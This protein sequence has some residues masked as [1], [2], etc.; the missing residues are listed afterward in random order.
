MSYKQQCKAEGAILPRIKIV[1]AVL[2]GMSQKEVA[3]H[4]RCSKN[5]VGSLMRAYGTLSAEQQ[6]A[7]SGDQSL[8]AADLSHF[9]ALACRSRA[10]R[11]N[12]RSLAPD[13]AQVILDVHAGMTMGPQR[14]RTHLSRQGAC[15]KT[16]TLAKIKG[17]YKRHGLVAKKVRTANKQRRSL[18]DYA[19]LA[20]FER[21]HMDTKHILDVHALPKDI[22]EKFRDTP[23]LPIYQWTIQDAKTRMRF[24]AYSHELSSFFGQRFLLFALEWLRAH[25]V[26]IRINVLFDGGSEFCSASA[27]KLAHWQ[28]FFEP[29]GVTVSQTNGDKTRQNLIERS[30]RSDDEEFYCPRGIHIATKTDFLLEAQ[31]WNIYWNCDRAHSG[32]GMDDMTPSEKLS[33]L[34]YAN[35]DAI[36]RFPT[37]ILE[38]IHRELL[39]MPSFMAAQPVRS[40]NVLTY[41]PRLQK[42][43]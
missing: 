40:Q 5:T 28:T 6:Q 3:A 11:G 13:E 35:V 36:G 27:R 9:T 10:P 19:R 16:Y 42:T 29:Y 39:S 14:M 21:L 43:P 15:M 1:R 33:R 8:A 41:Y 32:I 2:S 24:L 38:D 30:H 12:K 20:A 26:F 25:G 18:Y 34:G 4:W 22:Y 31:R 7:L 23:N 37:F 17:C